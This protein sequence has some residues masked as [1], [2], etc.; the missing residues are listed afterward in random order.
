MEWVAL[1]GGSEEFEIQACAVIN[2]CVSGKTIL[3]TV[4]HITGWNGT[5][6]CPVGGWNKLAF[7]QLKSN[8]ITAPTSE[9]LLKSGPKTQQP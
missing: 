7:G 2:F 8:L 4:L 6:Q 3:S 1:L 5:I 9:F